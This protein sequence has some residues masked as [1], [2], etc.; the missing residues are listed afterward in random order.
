MFSSHEDRLGMF[1]KVSQF[2]NSNLR[3]LVAHVPA[4]ATSKAKLED[5][6]NQIVTASAAARVD[7]SGFTTIKA[8]ARA[9][10][11]G[12]VLR[13]CRSLAA[14]AVLNNR[15]DIA[16]N[17]RFSPSGLDK[18]RD[19]D[20]YITA[21]MLEDLAAPVLGQL[22]P[23]LYDANNFAEL[24][25]AKTGFYSVIQLPKMQIGQR[26]LQNAELVRLITA[27]SI[28]LVRELDVLMALMAYAQ[29]TL[30]DAYQAHRQIDRTGS[31]RSSTAIE[32]EAP[33]QSTTAAL[34]ETYE[35]TAVIEVENL[36]ADK[37]VLG[38]SDN[39]TDIIG[40]TVEI[41]ARSEATIQLDSLAA[42]GD[43]IMIRNSS[44]RAVRYRLILR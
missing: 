22:Q 29:P 23:F 42:Y 43:F 41:A 19:N 34:V 3:G 25:T 31:R 7:T 9:V 40:N 12:Q 17:V 4:I 14:F 27:T 24:Q 15:P 21:Q 2:L 10:L 38:L 28:F 11:Q 8:D 30:L 44:Q 26:A 39:G 35:P 32:A 1:T 36:G 6:I 33:A 20:L 16:E 18:L 37:L 13:V 5:F